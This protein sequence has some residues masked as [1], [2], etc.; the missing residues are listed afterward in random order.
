MAGGVFHGY[1]MQYAINNG[2]WLRFNYVQRNIGGFI[3]GG[4]SNILILS[5]LGR[6]GVNLGPTGG[7]GTPVLPTASF[8]TSGTV[9]F[10]NLPTGTGNILVVD[11]NGNVFRST[12]GAK[13][14]D[15]QE[16]KN[17]MKNLKEELNELKKSLKGSENKRGALVV[18]Q[19]KPLLYQNSP[20]PFNQSTTIKYSIPP[21][22]EK[23]AIVISNIQGIQLKKILI[24]KDNQQEIIINK[25]ELAAGTYIYSLIVNEKIVDSKKMILTK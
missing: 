10:E 2:R 16:L 8:H 15:M 4:I 9:R 7:G 3:S 19:T 11:A 6:V 12:G 24:T 1:E 22:T 17:E 18:E 14:L 20:N 21:T 13:E 25:G 5:D 23:S